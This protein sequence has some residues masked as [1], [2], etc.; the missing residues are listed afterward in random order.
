DLHRVTQDGEPVTGQDGL[1]A[2]VV[3]DGDRGEVYLKVANTSDAARELDITIDGMS[4]AP[5]G[6]VYTISG[7]DMEAVNSF[8]EP[9]KVSPSESDI[10]VEDG[11]LKTTLPAKAFAVYKLQVAK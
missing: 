4:L 5:Q 8:D 11:K 3:S 1:Y 10:T 9:M 6:T 2:S 7:T